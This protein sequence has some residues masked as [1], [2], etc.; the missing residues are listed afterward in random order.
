MKR[1]VVTGEEN[2]ETDMWADI[3]SG[4]CAMEM[5]EGIH[6]KLISPYILT[7]IK[8]HIFGMA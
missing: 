7:I 5:N 2:H 8:E 1:A 6:N 4:Y 3:C